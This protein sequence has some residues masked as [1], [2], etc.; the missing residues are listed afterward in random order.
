MA[1]IE[2]SIRIVKGGTIQGDDKSTAALLPYTDT[3]ISYGAS[4]NLW[5]LSW[6][7]ANINASDF[8]IVYS[9][10]SNLTGHTSHYLKATNFG[11][12]IPEGAT[13]NGILVEIEQKYDSGILASHW[14]EVDHIRITVYY[15]E[16]PTIIGPFPTHFRT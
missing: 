9:V 13:I 10:K 16:A 3:Y 12:S 2:N 14:P 7:P 15:T 8:G 4:D 11:F 1:I 6:T 5:D